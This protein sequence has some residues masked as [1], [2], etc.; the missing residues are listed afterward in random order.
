MIKK[1]QIITIL[2]LLFS[3]QSPKKEN[4]IN[5]NIEQVKKIEVYNGYK[6]SILKMKKD[7]KTN[8]IEEYNQSEKIAPIK[9]KKSYLVLIYLNNNRIDTLRTNGSIFIGKSYYKTQENI[10]EKYIDVN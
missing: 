4:N 5:Y 2:L 8:F 3:C 1:L 10:I 9:F 7:F 6:G